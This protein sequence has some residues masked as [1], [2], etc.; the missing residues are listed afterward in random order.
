VANSVD[1]VADGFRFALRAALKTP[2]SVFDRDAVELPA[3][4]CRVV[5]M[6]T[7]SPP[8]RARPH[9]TT[10]GEAMKTKQLGSLRHG[11]V[12]ILSAC[13]LA[14]AAGSVRAQA[15]SA[16][17]LL[18]DWCQIVVDPEDGEE[19]NRWTFEPG[20]V[21]LRH[22]KQNKPVRTTWSLKGEQLDISMIGR[23]KIKR[24][25]DNEFRYRQFVDIRV[26]R[27]ACP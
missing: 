6:T 14:L 20:G 7:E 11:L 2:F 25:S 5:V 17:W 18:G 8:C 15:P 3:G 21:F 26:V 19:R 1:W 27:G 4:D 23:L 22:M 9:R 13:V 10:P 24:V 12:G 16:E